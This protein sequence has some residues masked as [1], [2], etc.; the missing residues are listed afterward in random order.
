MHAPRASIRSRMHT[1]IRSHSI[2]QIKIACVWDGK[3]SKHAGMHEYIYMV[4]WSPLPA[5]Y[6]FPPSL[7]SIHWCVYLVAMMNM[8]LNGKSTCRPTP[9]FP[10][11]YGYSCSN[12]AE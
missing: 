4:Q 6:L 7:S 10:S 3:L 2:S 12:M 9:S 11:K 8:R 5:V 1:C